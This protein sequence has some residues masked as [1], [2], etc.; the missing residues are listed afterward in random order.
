M[1]YTYMKYGVFNA[2][3]IEISEAWEKENIFRIC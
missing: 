2:H 3:I 1:K